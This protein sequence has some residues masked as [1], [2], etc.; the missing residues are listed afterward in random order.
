MT[1]NPGKASDF[2]TDRDGKLV[3]HHAETSKYFCSVFK[4]VENLIVFYHNMATPYIPT[5]TDF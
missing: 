2:L 4:A 5:I 3:Q 1:L